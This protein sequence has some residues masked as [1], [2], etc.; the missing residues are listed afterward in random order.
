MGFNTTL[1]KGAVAIAL[2]ALGLGIGLYMCI[3][4]DAYNGEGLYFPLLV[5]LDIFLHVLVWFKGG[6]G[7]KV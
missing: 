5:F 7:E 2:G 4:R 6:R 1:G 3:G